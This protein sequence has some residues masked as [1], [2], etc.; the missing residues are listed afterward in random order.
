M[1]L[2][3]FLGKAGRRLILN[4]GVESLKDQAAWTILIGAVTRAALKMARSMVKA[5]STTPT[6]TATVVSSS[7]MRFLA[8]APSPGTKA[9][10]TKVPGSLAN[11]TARASTP[12]HPMAMSTL[13][14]I[15]I[16]CRKEKV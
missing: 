13:A 14:A 5:P 4:Q 7:E 6:V 2:I 10:A 9:T 1:Y 11:L 3:C 8:K 12:T 15:R 16:T